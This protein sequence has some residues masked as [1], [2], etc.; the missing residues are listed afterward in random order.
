MLE[1]GGVHAMV[2]AL[3]EQVAQ[4]GSTKGL[5]QAEV[6]ALTTK[7]QSTMELVQVRQ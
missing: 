5:L 2:A 4:Q 7:L 3:E 1:L 6:H